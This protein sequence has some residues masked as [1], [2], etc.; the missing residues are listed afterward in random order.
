MQLSDPIENRY[1]DEM[2]RKEAKEALQTC[3]QENREAADLL[4]P[5]QKEE[6]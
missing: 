2:A 3:I 1:K 5:M 4:P 6:V